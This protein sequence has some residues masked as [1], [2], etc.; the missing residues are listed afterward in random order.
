MLI[1]FNDILAD[2]VVSA[3]NTDPNF[4]I[5]NLAHPFLRRR[6]QSTAT[7]DVITI[8]AQTAT[9]IN[10]IFIGFTN[11]ASITL[12]PYGFD[13]VGYDGDTIGYDGDSIGLNSH[14]AGV[15][16]PITDYVWHGDTTI[17]KV[18]IA[19]AASAAVYVGKIA[20]GLASVLPSPESFWDETFEDLSIISTSEAGQTLQEYVQ[21]LRVWGFAFPTLNRTD[22]RALQEEYIATGNGKPIFIDPDTDDLPALYC[23]LS[24]PMNTSKNKRQYRTTMNFTEAR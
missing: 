20:L 1:L 5:A 2:C 12:T 15:A 7:S 13:I 4:P 14:D 23:R 18:E 9:D 22:T 19:V 17:S 21:P 11:S 24:N 10:S 16:V 6:W 8:E 3:N